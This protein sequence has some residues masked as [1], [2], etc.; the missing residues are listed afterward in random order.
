MNPNDQIGAL[1]QAIFERAKTLADEHLRQAQRARERILADSADRLRLLEEKEMLLAKNR[2]EREFRRRVQSS[3]I[4]MQSEL[5]QLRWGLVLAVMEG[6]K[7]ELHALQTDD[8]RGR[9]LLNSLLL[10]AAQAIERSELIARVSD[11]DHRRVGETWDEAFRD[12]VPGKSITLSGDPCPCA[13]GVL[14]ESADG[15]IS[16][17][18]TFE[19]RMARFEADL[20]R[21]IL[22]RLFVAAGQMGTLFHG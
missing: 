4:R 3:E 19:G 9:A 2:A 20:Q 16:V 13:G 8:D 12:A 1:E 22:E 21:V 14:V 17:D 18:N 6:V 10:E 7:R 15:Q 11:L 5:D